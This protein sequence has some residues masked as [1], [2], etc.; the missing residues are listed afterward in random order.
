MVNLNTISYEILKSSHLDRDIIKYQK[1][2]NRI[3]YDCNV[4]GMAIKTEKDS[5]NQEMLKYPA[6]AEAM[7]VNYNDVDA[8]SYNKL[9][10]IIFSNHTIAR[11]YIDG[12]E[13]GCFSFLLIALFND[14]LKL[15]ADQKEFAVTEALK[16]IQEER[17]QESPLVRE[18]NID[19]SKTALVHG[20]TP[21]DI[22]YYILKNNNWTFQEKST[23]VDKFWKSEIEFREYIELLES[24]IINKLSNKNKRLS[25]NIIQNVI[26]AYDYYDLLE[27][28]NDEILAKELLKE[29]AF[30]N[31]LHELLKI[32]EIKNTIWWKL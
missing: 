1:L 21:Y 9:I 5:N 8:N 17:I 4:L 6:I 18:L 22:R 7:L 16:R 24:E 3:K 31:M 28:T 12:K 25:E 10:N 14:K 15:T 30:C 32:E 20:I 2:W 19:V 11:T 29:I 26:Y 13:K 27:I 23:L